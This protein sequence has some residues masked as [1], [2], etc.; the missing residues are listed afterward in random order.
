LLKINNVADQLRE[1]NLAVKN[2]RAGFSG[3]LLQ[4]QELTI[5]LPIFTNEAEFFIHD[6]DSEQSLA[7]LAAIKTNQ[8]LTQLPVIRRLVH[9][10]KEKYKQHL[11]ARKEELTKDL[12]SSVNQVG[13]ELDLVAA[14]SDFRNKIL[15]P[16]NR[17]WRTN[18]EV[19]ESFTKVIGLQQNLDKIRNNALIEIHSY[20]EEQ[21]K[22][23]NQPKVAIKRIVK[24]SPRSLANN[25]ILENSQDVENYIQRLKS[26]LMNQID[27]DNRVEIQ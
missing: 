21:A 27:A 3:Q 19:A 13:R 22:Q 8:D 11:T 24:I 2:T 7:K 4:W 16:L 1:L 26:E 15:L 5:N 17:E 23:N 20:A 25:H 18:L 12:E 9:S 6:E 10:L 14:E